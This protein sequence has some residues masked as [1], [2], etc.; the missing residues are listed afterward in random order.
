MFV[1]TTVGYPQQMDIY[2]KLELQ[3]LDQL[4]LA[5]EK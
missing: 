2:G 4:I 5:Q 1:T 3:E